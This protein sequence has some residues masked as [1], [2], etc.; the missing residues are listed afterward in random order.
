MNPVQS[1]ETPQ[2]YGHSMH[3]GGWPKL[4]W[5]LTEQDASLDQQDDASL[6]DELVNHL[7]S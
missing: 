1:F 7:F 2:L 5:A 6:S 3:A 4:G